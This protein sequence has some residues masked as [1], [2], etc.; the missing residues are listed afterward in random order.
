[1]GAGS[2][3]STSQHTPWACVSVLSHRKPCSHADYVGLLGASDT[4]LRFRGQRGGRLHAVKA[5]GRCKARL[6]GLQGKDPLQLPIVQQAPCPRALVT[7]PGPRGSLGSPTP[8]CSMAAA[9]ASR[10]SGKSAAVSTIRLSSPRQGA[11]RS[12]RRGRSRGPAVS[13][14]RRD[15][16]RP[17][18]GAPTRDPRVAFSPAEARSPGSRN[19]GESCM[20]RPGPRRLAPAER[21]D[22]IRWWYPD[23][24]ERLRRRAGRAEKKPRPR[25]GEALGAPSWLQRPGSLPPSLR[26]RAA[27]WQLSAISCDEAFLTLAGVRLGPS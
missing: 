17:L 5:R 21:T 27:S 6:Q 7:P 10:E 8:G 3:P 12:W 22:P 1:M 4:V 26:C 20:P 14:R 9:R 15:G 18:Q 16:G 2:H 25:R 19:I 11:G 13:A 23:S 24:G